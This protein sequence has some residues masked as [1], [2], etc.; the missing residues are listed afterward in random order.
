MLTNVTYKKDDFLT[1]KYS[2]VAT[3]KCSIFCGCGRIMLLKNVFIHVHYQQQYIKYVI[4][5]L[6]KRLNVRVF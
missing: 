5:F 2:M 3:E 6:C 1:F 4:T